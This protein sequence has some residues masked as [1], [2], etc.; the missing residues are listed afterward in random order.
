M[1]SKF[2]MSVA[3]LNLSLWGAV[4]AFA[5]DAAS[6]KDVQSQFE[7]VSQK[8]G[9]RLQY[10]SESGTTLTAAQALKSFSSSNRILM[11][12]PL[13][14]LKFRMSGL[15]PGANGSVRFMLEK[16]N[17]S[18]EASRFTV[19]NLDPNDTPERVLVSLSDASTILTSTSISL[20][21][22]ESKRNVAADLPKNQK[23]DTIGWT[24]TDVVEVGLSGSRATKAT[25][26]SI[27]PNNILTPVVLLSPLLLL[28]MISGKMTKTKW[29]VAI[30][31]PVVLFL[32][33][34]VS[35]F[36]E[37]ASDCKGTAN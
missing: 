17:E 13:L 20:Q 12:D 11:N 23:S 22:N 32:L 30:S 3:V 36:I 5:A 37:H 26:I 34:G 21:K 28:M 27:G 33:V 16:L 18:G 24:C 25:S 8:L 31:V 14:N 35:K 10:L 15:A 7:S 4:P 9:D 29:A 2:F 6:A 1:L 19:V